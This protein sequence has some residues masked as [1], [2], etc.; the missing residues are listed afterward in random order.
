MKVLYAIGSL[1]MFVVIIV[2]GFENIQSSCNYLMFFFWELDSSLAPTFVIF[3]TA[4][5][6]GI[7]G[8]FFTLLFKSIMDKEDEDDEEFVS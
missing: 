7:T 5:M 6:G 2:L 4:F 1:I 8:I 3:G